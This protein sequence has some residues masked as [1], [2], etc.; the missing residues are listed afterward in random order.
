MYS[1]QY[2]LPFDIPQLILLARLD[3]PFV[4]HGHIH[5]GCI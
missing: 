3:L 5:S 2:W 1:S 4:A